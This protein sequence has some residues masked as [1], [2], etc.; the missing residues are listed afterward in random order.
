MLAKSK[1]NNIE[2]L[3]SQ[4]LIDMDVSH[5]EFV[6]ILK[7]KNKYEKM[8]KNLRCENEEY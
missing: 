5:L 7:E 6:T 3:M 1:L 4:S 8:K 2:T